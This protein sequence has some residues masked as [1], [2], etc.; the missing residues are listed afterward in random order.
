MCHQRI[1]T[2]SGAVLLTHYGPLTVAEVF[3][4][5]EALS[6]GRSTTSISRARR[7]PATRTAVL[8]TSLR[9]TRP[10]CGRSTRPDVWLLGSS[11]S[12]RGARLGRCVRRTRQRRKWPGTPCC[13][14]VRPSPR[15]GRI[16]RPPVS[17]GQ[18]RISAHRYGVRRLNCSRRALL[19][20]GPQRHRS[21]RAD[22]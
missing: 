3:L 17:G 1:R 22:R 6:P 8:R 20:M 16:G 9:M 14:T 12:G 4:R 2:G 5:L 18:R 15:F 7:S 10:R 11:G 13:V 19:A 21:A